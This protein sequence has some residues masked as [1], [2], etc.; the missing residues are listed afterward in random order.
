MI[1]MPKIFNS[2]TLLTC[3]QVAFGIVLCI[4]I[5]EYKI[6]P[7]ERPPTPYVFNYLK[8][9][10]PLQSVLNGAK[11]CQVLTKR[12][13]ER[14]KNPAA[15]GCKSCRMHGAHKSRNVLRGKL[16]SRYKDGQ[17]SKAVEDEYRRAS[18]VLLTL[19]DIGDHLNMFSGNYKSGRKPNGYIKY[20]MN[21]PMQLSPAIVSLATK[22]NDF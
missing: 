14:C 13:K 1:K 9:I 3:A 2:H 4:G 5:T 8:F 19:R 12:G 21:D 11:Q 22:K 18:I 17:R 15:F 20:D 10:M 16:H 7:L 6:L